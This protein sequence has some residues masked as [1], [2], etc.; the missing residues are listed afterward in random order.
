M[1]EKGNGEAGGREGVRNFKKIKRQGRRESRS[2]S[3]MLTLTPGHELN[4]RLE[5]L[6]LIAP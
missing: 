2:T 1:E 5:L 6:E 3:I 4:S